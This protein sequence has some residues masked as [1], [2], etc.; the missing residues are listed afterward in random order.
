MAIRLTNWFFQTP[1]TGV[2]F[3]TNDVPTQAT[4][5]DL[6]DSK[7]NKWTTDPEDN[8]TL[9]DYATKSDVKTSTNNIKVVTPNNLPTFRTDYINTD[10]PYTPDNVV[11]AN[12]DGAFT[13]PSNNIKVL[14]TDAVANTLP[15]LV[16]GFG[17]GTNFIA[18][19]RK[20]VSMVRNLWYPEVV[21]NQTITSFTY[22]LD[23]GGA[24]IANNVGASVTVSTYKTGSRHKLHCYVG[25]EPF[26]SATTAN[27][28]LLTIDIPRAGITI[29]GDVYG[30]VPVNVYAPLYSTLFPTTG[31]AVGS[32]YTT[33]GG[34]NI[35][36]VI[37][38]P[39]HLVKGYKDSSAGFLDCFFNFDI[40]QS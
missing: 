17:L 12:S 9:H 23:G 3:L 31:L 26:T 11:L 32:I 28:I 1:A 33:G 10:V 7:V 4:F 35:R 39:R 14:D 30:I 29:L 25:N 16:M 20:V 27:Y 37:T 22:Q 15:K 18:Y 5:Q 2:R 6:I 40:L 19:L 24:S 36:C 34:T 8:P 38:I 13:I 21:S